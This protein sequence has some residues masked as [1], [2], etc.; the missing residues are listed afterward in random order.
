[1]LRANGVPV[2]IIAAMLDISL[3]TL[4][5]H[6]RPE[7]SRGLEKVRAAVGLAL[8][9]AALASAVR[10]VVIAAVLVLGGCSAL[11]VPTAQSI[12]G[13]TSSG[14]VTG[15]GFWPPRTWCDTKSPGTASLT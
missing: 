8:V 10:G 7:L 2:Q 15:G 1:M 11:N 4:R 3:P 12:Q 5:K 6:Y 13:L 14:T 9:R